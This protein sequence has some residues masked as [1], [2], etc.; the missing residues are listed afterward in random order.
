MLSQGGVGLGGDLRRQELL[1][2]REDHAG[3]TGGAAG[4]Q[5]P[6]R[7]LPLPPA[8]QAR[9]TDVEELDDLSHRHA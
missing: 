5:L 8:I 1:L 9:F 7:A 3:A 2:G 6:G 4:R